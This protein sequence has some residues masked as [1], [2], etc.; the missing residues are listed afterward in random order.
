MGR[1]GSLIL[2]W[3]VIEERFFEEKFL[4]CEPAPTD[5]LDG[6]DVRGGTSDRCSTP[7]PGRRRASTTIKPGLRPSA[8]FMMTSP[9]VVFGDGGGVVARRRGRKAWRSWRSGCSGGE[10]RTECRL[11]R[12][13]RY[14]RRQ[15]NRGLGEVRRR[16]I[17]GNHVVGSKFVNG[18]VG[19]VRNR[20]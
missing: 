19:G 16:L 3:P 18:G 13:G 8:L 12:I 11:A 14:S 6:L 5:V 1:W 7:S 4:L 20:C 10:S 15:R 17:G 2:T 9:S